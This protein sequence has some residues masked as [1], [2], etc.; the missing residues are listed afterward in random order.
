MTANGVTELGLTAL[1]RPLLDRFGRVWEPEPVQRPVEEHA[2]AV[3]RHG[4]IVRTWD[5]IATEAEPI[6]EVT[7]RRVLHVRLHLVPVQ[8]IQLGDL[9]VL[10]RGELSPVVGKYPCPGACAARVYICTFNGDWVRR[11]E[12]GLLLRA[13]PRQSRNRPPGPNCDHTE[14]G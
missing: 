14:F 8:Q 7:D 10:F 2:V 6:I 4:D 11:P 9:V 12:N 13:D 1:H 3:Y 5:G